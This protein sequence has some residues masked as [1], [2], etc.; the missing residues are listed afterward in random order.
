MRAF[1]PSPMRPSLRRL[2]GLAV[3]AFFAGCD[4]AQPSEDV[5]QRRIHTRYEL[6]YD[7]DSDQTFATAQFRFG[8]PTGTQLELSGT[9]EVTFNGQRLTYRS[10]P[11]VN[12]SYYERTYVGTISTGT[13]RFVDA[14]GNVFAN[15]ATLRPI[16]LPASVEPIERDRSSELAWAGAPLAVG[17]T[18]TVTLSGPAASLAVFRQTQVGATS[19]ILN[20]AGLRD[21]APGAY[22]LTLEREYERA[23]DEAPEAGGRVHAKYQPPSITVEVLL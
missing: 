10:I 22:R 16:G 3:L 15:A 5:N 2:L 4:P 12:L 8:G 23:P 20:A 1:S 14:D 6:R 18:V 17:E 11:G 13:F 21:L 7:G 9:S 19:V